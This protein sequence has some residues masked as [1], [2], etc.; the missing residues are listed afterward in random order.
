MVGY[1]VQE[2]SKGPQMI[3]GQGLFVFL[4]GIGGNYL[5]F[6]MLL[7]MLFSCI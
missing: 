4:E 6:T 7:R 2:V 1:E 3:V 5:P